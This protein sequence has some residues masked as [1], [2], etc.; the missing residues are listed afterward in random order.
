MTSKVTKNNIILQLGDI[1][2]IDSPSNSN[3]H[4]KIF[5]I[6]FINNTKINL[7]NEDTTLTLEFKDNIFLEESIKKIHLLFR[8]ESPSYIKQNN[9]TIDKIITIYFGGKLPFVLNGRIINIEDDMI[10]IKAIP[11]NEIYY[12]DFAYSGIPEHLNIDKI[13][14]RSN[15]EDISEL[16]KDDLEEETEETEE[17]KETK[18]TKETKESNKKSDKEITQKIKEYDDDI[19]TNNYDEFEEIILDNID[20]ESSPE[21]I[22]Y[23][24]E[25]PDE[26]KRYLL[27][28]QIEDYLDNTL[29][30]IKREDLS[31][32]IKDKIILESIRF[33]E[34]RNMF[35]YFDYNNI[36]SMKEENNKFVKPLKKSLYNLNKKFYWLLPIGLYKRNIFIDDIDEEEID[37]NYIKNEIGKYIEDLNT[38]NDKWKK[39]SSKDTLYTYQK[40]IDELLSQFDNNVNI[41]S[42]EI[43]NTINGD[44]HILN[45][46][47]DDYNSFVISKGKFTRKPFIIDHYGNNTKTNINIGGFITLPE[48]FMNF[49]KINLDY[50]S[51]YERSNLNLNFLNYYNILNNSTNINKFIIDDHD[52]ESFINSDNNIYK[53][54]ELFKTINSFYI[55]S[56]KSIDYPIYYNH[57]LESFIPTTNNIID[58]LNKSKK[59]LNNVSLTND[60][61]IF[62]INL[63]EI[64]YEN[65]KLIK[66]ILSKNV[67]NYISEKKTN[68]S[69]LVNLISELNSD[70][71]K[72]LKTE[73]KNSFD[74]ISKDLKDELFK[75]YNIDEKLYN[76]EELY[77]YFIKNDGGAFLFNNLNKTIMDL[78]VSN[79][80][81][82]FIKEKDKSTKEEEKVD[83]SE[84]EKY[85]LSKKYTSIDELND[86][87]N[88]L[89]YFDVIYDNTYYGLI[90]EYINEKKNM[91]SEKFLEFLKTEIENKM[92][93]TKEKA[94]R[95]AKAIINEKKEVLDGD[96]CL[97]IDKENKKNVIYV[98]KDNIWIVEEKFKDNFYIDSN[99]IFCDSNKDCLYKDEKCSNKANTTNKIMREDIDEILKTFNIEYDISIEDIKKKLNKSY[100]NSKTYLNNV[101]NIKK[102]KIHYVNNILKKLN[103]INDLKIISSP[104][105]FLRDSILNYPDFSKR[106]IFI[107]TFCLKLTRGPINSDDNN[108]L[109]CIKTG[110]K[111]IPEFLLKL[112]NVFLSK[113]DYLLELDTICANQ[114][115]ISDDN[116]YWVDKHSGYIIKNIDFNSEEGYDD[117]GFNLT[118]KDLIDEFNLFTSEKESTNSNIE[119]IKYVTNNVTKNMNINLD[120]HKEFIIQ[121]VIKI[122]NK[123]VPSKQQYDKLV[124]ETAKKEGKTKKLP[125]YEET[126]NLSLL[127]LTLSFISICIL[128]NI[129]NITT[130]KTFPGCVKYLDGYPL[131]DN[132]NNIV[133]IACIASK[134]KSSIK[135]WNSILKM[136]ESMLVKKMVGIIDKYILTNKDIVELLEAKKEYLKTNI[137]EESINVNKINWH[138]FSPPLNLINIDSSELLPLS[139]DFNNS[140]LDNIRKGVVNNDY[141]VI[142]SKILFLSISI[143]EDIEN[144]ISKKELIL[145]NSAGEPFLE[146]SC[147]YE[148]KSVYDYLIKN[149]KKIY[150]KNDLIGVYNILKTG[151]SELNKA[152]IIYDP[153]NSKLNYPKIDNYFSEKTIYKSFIYYC[154]FN[155]NIPINDDLKAICMDKPTEILKNMNIDE[156]ISSLK[157]Q[158]KNYNK[159]NFEDLLNLIN[160]KNINI[161]SNAT[162]S[163]S[164]ELIRNI[165]IRYN[166][167]TEEKNYEN[168]TNKLE[169]LLDSYTL[170]SDGSLT[171]SIKNY[172][173]STN[174]IIE[175]NILGLMKKNSVLTKQNYKILEESIKINFTIY[176]HHFVINYLKNL[177]NIFP[178]IIVNKNINY[179]AVPKHWN[180]SEVHN[181]DIFNIIKKYYLPLMTSNVFPEFNKIFEIVNNKTKILIDLLNN[182][183]YKNNIEIKD[184]KKN[185]KLYSIFDELFIENFYKFIF[186]NV[187]NDILDVANSDE[188]ILSLD[189]TNETTK[190]KINDDIINYLLTFFNIMKQHYKLINNSHIKVKQNIL[191]AKEKEK[192]LITDYLKDLSQEERDIETIFKNNKLEKWSKGLQKGLTQYVKE[193]YDE[194]RAELEKQALKEHMLNKKSNV[195][196]MNKEI[197]KMDIEEEM[198]TA[199]EIEDEEYNMDNIPDDDDYNSDFEYD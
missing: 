67:I 42:T 34:L 12:I 127:V 38:I 110:I 174:S 185:I 163:S 100:S 26:Q 94:L 55:N 13:I 83:S 70:N 24:V 20:F 1:I 33:K 43:A 194:E 117:T 40:Y 73:Y 136:S 71:N 9:I 88:K 62:N 130:K 89:I 92:N 148:E 115:T 159:S 184:L 85:F 106:Q 153:K 169:E 171:R 11:S 190:N 186:L 195:T 14:L 46:N 25:V 98:R 140:V 101:L 5:I 35:S 79:L 28:E 166:N 99:K 63:N 181:N 49:S 119:M 122:I 149:D 36:P 157:S 10:E 91:D 68:E 173:M 27:D 137:T 87:N 135:P 37:P 175:S 22:F 60:L 162:L 18:G 179:N 172:L 17:T 93:L 199:Q 160:E 198:A 65:F 72:Y 15:E 134:M 112:A 104:Y 126:Y 177:I 108:W 165:I 196:D 52:N 125:D 138:N 128:I 74:L 56:I 139:S 129:P 113:G 81:Q 187:I 154:N 133:Y 188:F 19:N 143:I 64:H 152:V 69:L 142:N 59:Y 132:T 7:K 193:N 150:E 32:D 192:D 147:C 84:C 103:N 191:I 53:N 183:Y 75:N 170:V 3:L 109:Y 131:H 21:E 30:S 2:K 164:F 41:Y 86:D 50:S 167:D 156:A 57:L 161:I 141:D 180:L 58:F 82:N 16:K 80:L 45:D 168:I 116:N 176:D 123:T 124:L 197:Y 44:M 23:N 31:D 145:Q 155:N 118:T 76:N 66:D 90:N 151:I 96:Y 97:L 105:E 47:Y 29:H 48:K 146:N 120:N 4:E 178:N 189:T 6:D 39:K 61:Q 121:N 77:S 54:N 95:E 111:L 114:G 107:K 158:G 102:E 8:H 144:I 51:I 78:I 182:I